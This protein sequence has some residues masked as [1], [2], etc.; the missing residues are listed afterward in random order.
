MQVSDALSGSISLPSA[1]REVGDFELIA[2]IKL[3][4]SQ[5]IVTFGG[6]PQTYSAL[7]ITG[8][9]LTS[10]A[11]NPT[12]QINGDTNTSNYKGHHVWGTGASS[13]N[14]NDQSGSCYWNYNP[15]SSYPSTFVMNW[16]NYTSSNNKTM[17]TIA[18]CSTNGGTQEIAIWSGLYMSSNPITSISLNGNG[19]S[20]SAGTV[21]S[22]YGVK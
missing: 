17:R 5:T 12:W 4:S 11:T 2:R 10:G 21:I 19:A 1:K 6:I 13:V 8:V 7:E 18:G 22:L 20:F 9:V 15:S 3:T 16:Q 14:A